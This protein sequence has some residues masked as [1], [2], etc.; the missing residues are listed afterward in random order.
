[1]NVSVVTYELERGYLAFRGE[2]QIENNVDISTH[3]EEAGVPRK[4]P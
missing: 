3:V 4:Q 1:M 2:N